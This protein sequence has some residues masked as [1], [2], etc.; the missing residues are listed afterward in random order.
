MIHCDE[1]FEI[2][3]RGP[4][5][6]GAASDGIVESHLSHCDECR[7]L[8]EALRPAVELLQEAIA[9]DEGRDLPRYW[10]NLAEPQAGGL[11]KSTATKTKPPARR[12]F[13]QRPAT[14]QAKHFSA[15]AVTWNGAA[16]LA[17]AV[18]LGLVLAGLLRQATRLHDDTVGQIAGRVKS[19]RWRLSESG[20]RWFSEQGLNASCRQPVRGLTLIAALP[21]AAI[22][23]VE[24]I[25]EPR[26]AETDVSP[27]VTAGPAPR[28]ACCLGCHSAQD[29]KLLAATA[30]G[31]L[32]QACGACHE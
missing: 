13:G 17:A 27:S 28:L 4:F 2:L 26:D 20:D 3:T 23:A 18:L 21:E 19:A 14:E 6:T 12:P 15:Q 10:G 25:A 32:V 30:V 1:V 9:S 5:P 31:R 22:K 29:H 16:R 8:A 11:V 7:R 24:P